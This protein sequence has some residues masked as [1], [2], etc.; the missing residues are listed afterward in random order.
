MISF[1]QALE[2]IRS[3]VQ[4]KT[5]VEMPVAET[6]A[7]VSAAKYT[8]P[9]P[10]PLFANSAMDGFA[11]RSAEATQL[12]TNF[13]VIGSS[14]AGDA[15]PQHIADPQTLAGAWEIMT[16]APLPE[17]YDAVIRIEDVIVTDRNGAGRPSEIKL[18]QTVVAGQNVR[19]AGEDMQAGDTVLEP[20]TV[21]GPQ[22]I[23]ALAMV[24]ASH[25][26]VCPRPYVKV[27]ATG[28]ELVDSPDQA[29]LPGQIRNSNGPFLMAALKTAGVNA[30]YLGTVPDDPEVF[31]KMLEACD[32][33]KPDMIIS[34][35]AVSMGRYDFV[36]EC[37]ERHGARIIFHK[38]SV[39]PGKPVLFAVLPGGSLF[40]GLPGN[41]IAVAAGARFFVSAALAR[42]QGLEPE[43]FQT[44]RLTAHLRKKKDL[45]FFARAWSST[46]PRG[47]LEVEVLTG[48]ASFMVSSY[49][50]ANSWVILDEPVSE[51]Q[52]G[53]LVKV[54]PLHGESRFGTNVTTPVAGALPVA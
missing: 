20:G 18:L 23:K 43:Q 14:A 41:P 25:V 53:Q 16:G 31:L 46:N 51:Y 44:G 42:L 4:S 9:E 22:H 32:R 21:I 27:I 54:V 45:C 48:Q 5:P 26:K 50:E 1:S 10:Q 47:V 7:L 3:E 24:G 39:R 52:A 36:P 15:S 6:L 37:L 38:V 29:L 12:S 11:L 28:K 40:M 19:N 33:E 30:D 13:Q 35:G 34:S 17:I 2:A 8:A 49:L